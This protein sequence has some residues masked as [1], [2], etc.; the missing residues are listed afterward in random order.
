MRIYREADPRDAVVRHTTFIA[1]VLVHRK[2]E[3]FL[4]IEEP[5]GDGW[6]LPS[7]PTISLE[8]VATAAI[9]IMKE[10]AGVEATIKGVM[11]IEYAP[12]IP[13]YGS[14]LEAR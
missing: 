1:S 9:R 2:H 14:N 13:L 8:D 3:T 11:F 7:G 4:A 6:Y 12:V 10:E 5:N